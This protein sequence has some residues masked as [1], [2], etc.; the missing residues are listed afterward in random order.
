VNREQAITTL[1]SYE[2]E[3]KAL[4]VVSASRFGRSR[5]M[6]LAAIPM[7]MWS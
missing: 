2:A 1:R 5:V 7:S 6:M 3:L 4:G